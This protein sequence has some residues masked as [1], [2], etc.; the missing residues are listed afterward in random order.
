M[1]C[2]VTN[3]SFFEHARV[4]RQHATTKGALQVEVALSLPASERKLLLIPMI[5]KATDATIVR[6]S[7]GLNNCF[8]VEEGANFNLQTEGINFQT[9]FNEAENLPDVDL[10]NLS[11]NGVYQTLCTYGVEAARASIIK[12]IQDVF[13]VYGIH[14]DPR[15]LGLLADY[16][17]FAGGFRALNRAGIENQSSPLLQMSFETTTTFL[18]NAATQGQKDELTSPSARLVFGRPIRSGTGMVDILQGLRM[19]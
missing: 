1:L 18:T 2:S 16:M 13:G 12:Q 4:L 11:C 7:E 14:V 19:N 5:E 6:A 3:N 10:L 15:H 8:V 17:T 9:I